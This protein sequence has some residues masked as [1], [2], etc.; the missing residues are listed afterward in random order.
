MW[1]IWG[2][3]GCFVAFAALVLLP[4]L[5]LAADK[6]KRIVLLTNG[7]SP[8]WDAA[9]V[10]LQEAEKK[11]ELSQAGLKAVMEINDGTPG[12]QIAKLQQFGTQSDIVGVAV[13]ALDA[14][15]TAVAK[16][17]KKLAK[18]GVHVISVD[19]DLNRARF[20]DARSYY[21]GTDNLRAGKALGIAAQHVLEAR[22]VAGGS[23]VCFVGR[24]GAHNARERMDGF[25]EAIDKK[26]RE[27]DRMGD[28][29]NRDRAEENVRNAII[30]NRDLVCL[31]G[32]WSYNAPAIVKVVKDKNRRDPNKKQDWLSV[33]AFDA[34]PVAVTQMADGQ[35]DVILVQNPYEMGYQSVRL[36]KA[37][38]GKDQATI[39][40]MF[41]GSGKDADIYDTG[42]K[43]VVP[44]EKSPLK[45]E[46]FDDKTQF[47]TLGEFREW[48]AKYNLK[49]S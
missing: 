29:I 17:M 9:R 12:G 28:E 43:V 22:G 31:V 11:F 46:M 44:N 24:T 21:I 23:Y 13:S 32:I 36:L 33:V 19:A 48:L 49:G 37:M 15:N 1:T 45:A 30:K 27:A 47:M 25:K 39:K 8:Y 20:R 6:D 14:D 40:E 41:P 4:S 16:E 10:G 3:R 18:N 35:I 5:V 42:L 7:E 38:V 34:E 26:Y 2:R